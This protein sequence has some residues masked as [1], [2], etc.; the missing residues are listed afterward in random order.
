MKNATFVITTFAVVTFFAGLVSANEAKNTHDVSFTT[1]STLL[2]TMCYPKN[3]KAPSHKFTG[4][5]SSGN[6][7][8]KFV[9]LARG[10][11]KKP[12]HSVRY[13]VSKGNSDENVINAFLGSVVTEKNKKKKL[14]YS[15]VDSKEYPENYGNLGLKEVTFSSGEKVVFSFEETNV[16]SGQ[17]AE[18]YYITLLISKGSYRHVAFAKLSTSVKNVDV[19]VMF[20]NERFSKY[21]KNKYGQNDPV[22]EAVNSII[23][24]L[25]FAG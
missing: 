22:N 10:K 9:C 21:K 13:Y 6:I 12:G 1:S 18:V 19:W 25:E 2:S 17:K 3:K 20:L 23:S 4:V 24:G 16:R 5:S 7:L 11:N 8:M 14:P 15:V